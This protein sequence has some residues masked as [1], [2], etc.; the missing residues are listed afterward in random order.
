LQASSLID[1]L[2]SIKSGDV[3]LADALDG[4]VS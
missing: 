1:C 2:K 3:D 4:R